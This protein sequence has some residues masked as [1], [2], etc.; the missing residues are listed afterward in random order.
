LRRVS[1]DP[2]LIRMMTPRFDENALK[3]LE[4]RYLKRDESGRV[5]ESPDDLLWRVA[6]AVAEAERD[7]EPGAD[8]ESLA[9]AFHDLMADRRFFP[10]SPALGAGRPGAQLAA[11]FVLP[12]EDDLA[13]IFDTLKHAA[14]IH[15][16][17]GGTGFDFSRLRHAGDRVASTGGVASGPVSFLRLYDAATEVIKQGGVRRGANMGVLRVD[18]PDILAFV[19]EKASTGRLPNFNVSVGLTEAFMA[20]MEAGAYYDLVNPRDGRAVRRLEARK[21]WDAIVHH[22]WYSGEPGVLF[23][24]RIEAAN[25]VPHVGRIEATNPCGEQPLLPYESCTLGSLNLAAFV[26]SGEVD[27]EGL[28][29]AVHLAVRFLDDVIEANH[30]P[31]DQIAHVTHL[32]RKIGL[33]VMGLADLLITLGVPYDTPDALAVAE[34]VMGFIHDEGREAS[35][36]L[37]EKRGPFP[38]WHGSRLQQAGMPP[39]RNA[40][41]TTVAPTGTLSLLAGCSSGIEPIYA[42]RFVRHVLGGERLE[43]IQPA[44]R[45]ALVDRGFD[46][47]EILDRAQ[48]VGS[49]R[50]LPELPDDLTRVFV[51]AL[52]VAPSWHVKMQAVFQ[53]YSDNAVSKTINLPEEATPEDVDAAFR[54]AYDLGC[55]GITIY[56]EGSRPRQVLDRREGGGNGRVPAGATRTCPDCQSPVPAEGRCLLCRACGW[57][58]CIVGD[59]G[60][61]V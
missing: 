15:Q 37:A 4:R 29:R 39:Q 59:D 9:E 12:V 22:A 16:S 13:S 21:V 3:V 52:D 23:L 56:R 36:V 5:V 14:L 35:A 58:A 6:R 47:D 45:K 46:P 49:L 43:E 40:T 57:S 51:T 2:N 60:H 44:V 28:G 31:L 48:A 26:Q 24:D 53:R 20:A 32:T 25:P 30:Y 54:L 18:H 19:G 10:N 17:G 7:L 61:L 27:F 42:V 38:A 8:V 55:K 1:A 50:R 34:R 11:C 33:G 41:V